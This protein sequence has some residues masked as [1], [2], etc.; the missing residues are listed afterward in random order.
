MAFEG[1]IVLFILHDL[2][3]VFGVFKSLESPESIDFCE[4]I[5]SIIFPK[6]SRP[7]CLSPI[8]SVGTA[9]SGASIIPLDELPTMP[10]NRDKAER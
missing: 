2:L 1:E 4:S 3:I 6:R 10:S 8:F 5:A 9:R 7:F